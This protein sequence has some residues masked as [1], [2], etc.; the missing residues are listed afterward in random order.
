MPKEPGEPNIYET[1]EPADPKEVA[2]EK[3]R[4]EFLISLLLPEKRDVQGAISDAFRVNPD[5]LAVF[6]TDL[7][8]SLSPEKLTE[9]QD[10]CSDINVMGSFSSINFCIGEMESIQKEGKGNHI[11]RMEDLLSCPKLLKVMTGKT[12]PEIDFVGGNVELSTLAGNQNLVAYT[13]TLK[14]LSNQ[15]VVEKTER[16]R[17][18]IEESFGSEVPNDVEKVKRSLS[19]GYVSTQITERVKDKI[20]EFAKQQPLAGKKVFELGGSTIAKTLGMAGAEAVNFDA[21]GFDWEQW[22]KTESTTKVTNTMDLQNCTALL[23]QIDPDHPDHQFDLTTSRMVFDQGSGIESTTSSGEYKDAAIEILKVLAKT[24]KPGGLSIHQTGGL[25]ILGTNEDRALHQLGF[26]KV[27]NFN[28]H[29]AEGIT[30]H[31]YFLRLFAGNDTWNSIH[32][33]LRRSGAGGNFTYP[34]VVLRRI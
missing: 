20:A 26:E 22:G 30:T 21:E 9:L 3:E 6:M 25:E 11:K 14:Q 10:L 23:D 17:D 4:Q 28:Q 8:Y 5:H 34:T 19:R 7:V 29:L 33:A 16:Y 32:H 13:E 2:L 18:I 31:P 15:M 1:L 12:M 27:F 24:T